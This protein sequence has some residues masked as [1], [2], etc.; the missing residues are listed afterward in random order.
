MTESPT[1]SDPTT[2]DEDSV[3]GRAHLLPEE[4]AVGSADPEKQAEAILQES[5]ER[6]EHPEDTK[7][8]SSQVP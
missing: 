1:P 6:T 8:T 3:G 7:A 2:P 4:L 5:A